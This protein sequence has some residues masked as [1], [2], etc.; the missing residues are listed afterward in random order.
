M[1]AELSH[2]GVADR[3]MYPANGYGK[4]V[5]DA[6]S[7]CKSRAT[8]STMSSSSRISSAREPRDPR[9]CPL[10]GASRD[11]ESVH[12]QFHDNAAGARDSWWLRQRDISTNY[13]RSN[14]ALVGGPPV[15]SLP[16]ED[17]NAR[18][19]HIAK[20]LREAFAG[21]AGHRTSVVGDL[22]PKP[23]QVSQDLVV[24]AEKSSKASTERRKTRKHRHGE[25]TA[26]ASRKQDL[27]AFTKSAAGKRCMGGPQRQE[28]LKVYPAAASV[29]E[30]AGLVP[31]RESGSPPR[32]ENHFDVAEHLGAAG[33]RRLGATPRKEGLRTRATG[34]A[35]QVDE[36]VFGR[37]M[38]CSD[39]RVAE[40]AE[41]P[42]FE[43]AAGRRYVG[44]VERRE[45][46]KANP[47]KVVTRVDKVVLGRELSNSDDR[48][49]EHLRLEAFKD[50]A[51]AP[52]LGHVDR[53]EGLKP[54][55]TTTLSQVDKI[56]F[57][58]ELGS[59]TERIRDHLQSAQ[60]EG[61]AGRRYIGH[62]E[63]DGGLRHSHMAHVSTVDKAAFGR[64]T[65]ADQSD[66]HLDAACWRGAAGRKYIGAPDR[67]EGRQSVPGSGMSQVDE[68]VWGRDIDNSGERQRLKER[69]RLQ[70]IGC[71]SLSA[72]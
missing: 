22:A 6:A 64:E 26:P 58:H 15:F 34:H 10:A 45:G 5:S 66:V 42:V 52:C 53:M 1:M 2:H 31:G 55:L 50:A 30:T 17:L 9:A 67:A 44:H 36:V 12:R 4:P 51:G 59:S 65:A 68:I 70:A 16:N 69:A 25:G 13:A 3:T 47:A 71:L 32:A 41:E 72:R 54:D 14:G 60:F 8:A 61:A 20:Q 43:G 21:A 48:L 39:V 63:K 23:S 40:Y 18:S 56:V 33:K 49:K 38:D 57:G 37:D 35:S 29:C 62:P 19:R 27:V 11:Y 7:S 24:D 28:G 46:I